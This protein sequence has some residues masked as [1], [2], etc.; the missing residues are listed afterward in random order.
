MEEE[1]IFFLILLIISCL[2]VLLEAYNLVHLYKIFFNT[3]EWSP[4]NFYFCG[5]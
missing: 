4:N 2:S 1:E 5:N 3:Q